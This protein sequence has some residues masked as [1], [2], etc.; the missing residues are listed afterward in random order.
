MKMSYK[1]NDRPLGKREYKKLVQIALETIP[2]IEDRGD[3][4]SRMCD[5]EDFFET[6]VWCLETAL[7]DAYVLG[8]QEGIKNATKKSDKEKKATVAK[9]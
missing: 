6:A 7:I 8:K 5:S 3:L 1:E 9:A 4:D 2:S